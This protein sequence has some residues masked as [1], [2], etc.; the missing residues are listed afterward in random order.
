MMRKTTAP[1]P[2]SG[3]ALGGLT[4]LGLACA[5]L[6]GLLFSDVGRAAAAT[7]EFYVAPGGNDA[8]S[9]S[10]SAPWQTLAHAASVVSAPGSVVHVAP[11]TYT[12]ASAVYTHYSGTSAARIVY[13]SDVLWAAKVVVTTDRDV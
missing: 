4:L 6:S 13:V 7:A 5:A 1:G 3:R 12:S 9:G 10:A 8:N 2:W 11:G